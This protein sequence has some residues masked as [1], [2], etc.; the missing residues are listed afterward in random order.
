[1]RRII[2]LI[3]AFSLLLCLAS[4]TLA[5]AT[6]A[7]TN[8]RTLDSVF[9]NMQY[10]GSFDENGFL[11]DSEG[12]IYLYKGTL[13]K[14]GLTEYIKQGVEYFAD[15]FSLKTEYL[16]DVNPNEIK[17]ILELCNNK[18]YG[19]IINKIYEAFPSYR[20]AFVLGISEDGR[21]SLSN[22]AFIVICC[23]EKAITIVIPSLSKAAGISKTDYE[24]I[25]KYL[26]TFE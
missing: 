9:P 19:W 2:S 14:G 10:A 16:E 21:S 23:K 11:A 25:L 4:C 3:L 6:Y 13:T 5:Y 26:N 18:S 12:L 15:S 17:S 7:G 1:M 20:G 24:K 22:N 8:F